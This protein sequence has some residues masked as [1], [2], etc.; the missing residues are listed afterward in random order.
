MLGPAPP[1]SRSPSPPALAALRR[2]TAHSPPSAKNSTTPVARKPTSSPPAAATAPDD[3]TDMAHPSLNPPTDSQSDPID[4]DSSSAHPPSLSAAL[5]RLKKQRLQSAS[6][7][8][9]APQPPPG[10]PDVG[11]DSGSGGGM[12]SEDVNLRRVRSAGIRPGGGAA[13]PLGMATAAS[14]PMTQP[15]AITHR[16]PPPP[17]V[18]EAVEEDES[19][20]PG[21]A[22]KPFLKRRSKA[23]PARKVDWSHVKPRTVT[24]RCVRGLWVWNE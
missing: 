15:S 3:S 14:R 16:A 6:A 11:E 4:K 1:V 13:P 7:I 5:L 20:H 10:A 8:L 23:V 24:T 19:S 18:V 17:R 12:R 9:R 22:G 21:G 2:S